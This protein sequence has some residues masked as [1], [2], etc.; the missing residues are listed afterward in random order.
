MDDETAEQFSLKETCVGGVAEFLG[1]GN[2]AAPIDRLCQ[3]FV[4]GR[5]CVFKP[6]PVNKKQHTVVAEK[7]LE[8]LIRAG[9]LA[10][11]SGGNDVGADL[12]NDRQMNDPRGFLWIRK[13]WNQVRVDGVFAF[14]H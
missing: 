5:V 7:I 4:K 14:G 12:V 10:Y 8:P 1:A 2:I 6:N 11:I 13:R 3:M 9:Y